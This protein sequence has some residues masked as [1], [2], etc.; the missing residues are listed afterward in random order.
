MKREL[1]GHLAGLNLRALEMML[2][3]YRVPHSSPNVASH[4]AQYDAGRPSA[5][6]G[7]LTLVH[8]SRRQQFAGWNLLV[9]VSTGRRGEPW[10]SRASALNSMH[11]TH[12]D[13]E[14]PNFFL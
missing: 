3:P 10:V 1:S 5:D 4:S 2:K 7:R 8:F 9:H 14:F 6:P 11:R 13:W 12:P